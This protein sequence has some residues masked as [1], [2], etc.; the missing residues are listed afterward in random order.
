M[1]KV[2]ISY[3][4]TGE[5]KLQAKTQIIGVFNNERTAL[6]KM[7]DALVDNNYIYSDRDNDSEEMKMYQTIKKEMFNKE[8]PKDIRELLHQNM[9]FLGMVFTMNGGSYSVESFTV[10]E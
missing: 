6:L 8:S 10:G 2:W 7:F 9:I 3:I 1:T 4:T 5:Q